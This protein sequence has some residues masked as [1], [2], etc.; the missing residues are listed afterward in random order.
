MVYS[1]DTGGSLKT[2]CY[3]WS[4]FDDTA[5]Q[6]GGTYFK[7]VRVDA[8]T[9]TLLSY[10]TYEVDIGYPSPSA[11][12]DFTLN[13]DDSWSLL[14]DFTS[15]VNTSEFVYKIDNNGKLVKE[16][17]LPITTSRRTH[18]PNEAIR[19]WWSLMTQ[20]PVTATLTMKGLLRPAMLMSYVKVNTYFYG[21]KHT[22]SGLYIITKQQDSIS[23]SGYRTTLSLTRVGGDEYYA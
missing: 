21:H 17:T 15:S 12:V 11:I 13:N 14:Y 7:V 23:S 19:N 3:F 9:K 5:N 18:L 6:Y 1:G 4:V 10:N 8:N 16:E 2:S 22:S 20:F